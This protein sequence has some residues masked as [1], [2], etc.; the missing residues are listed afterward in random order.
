MPPRFGDRTLGG[1]TWHRVIEPFRPIH[2]ATIPYIAPAGDTQKSEGETIVRYKQIQEPTLCPAK[3]FPASA[4]ARPLCL[5][6]K[7]PGW[8]PTSSSGYA[9]TNPKQL[10]TGGLSRSRHM[11]PGPSSASC[12]AIA[13][14]QTKATWLVRP[15]KLDVGQAARFVA[16]A[17]GNV[18][19]GS[20][21]TTTQASIWRG[22][23]GG[24]TVS[25]ARFISHT[26]ALSRRLG[27]FM[28]DPTSHSLSYAR[29]DRS[30]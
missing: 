29:P 7:V 3:R 30:W 15:P 27:L 24:R 9:T 2:T 12:R 4:K 13:C 25:P 22:W 16:A 6:V 14:L 19:G 17:T 20:T 11:S 28:S 26:R 21:A 10:G 1:D 8:V 5:C 23:R 18:A